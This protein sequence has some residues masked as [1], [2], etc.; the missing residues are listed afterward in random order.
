[1]TD[2][3]AEYGTV[4]G[5]FA[6]RVRGVARPGGTTL[7]PSTGG[8]RRG[9]H[10]VGWFPAFM[11]AGAGVDLPTGRA[12][13]DDPVAAWALQSDGV[14]ALLDDPAT[15]GRTFADPRLGDI[16]LDQAIDMFYTTDVFLQ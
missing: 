13:D 16:P 8:L 7:P 1:M 10:L 3:A 6:Q 14:P 4:A 15:R 5:V 2:A 12:V 9:A 11:R